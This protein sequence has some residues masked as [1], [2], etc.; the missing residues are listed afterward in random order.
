MDW[1]QLGAVRWQKESKIIGEQLKTEIEKATRQNAGNPQAQQQALKAVT[2]KYQSRMDAVNRGGQDSQ[3]FAEATHPLLNPSNPE[4]G[5]V[6]NWLDSCIDGHKVLTR[7]DTGE[8]VI[9]EVTPS[10]AGVQV[11]TFV[12]GPPQPGTVTSVKASV[13]STCRSFLRNINKS[14]AH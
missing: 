14:V 5:F 2:E 1:G 10:A 8:P 3:D 6:R 12:A 7:N 11:Q 13:E 9:E 4:A